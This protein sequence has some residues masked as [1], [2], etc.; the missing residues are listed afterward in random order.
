M[1][2]SLVV[3]SR[4]SPILVHPRPT[5]VSGLLTIVMPLFAPV[6][7][8]SMFRITWR[9][10]RLSE[11]LVA[12]TDLVVVSN[13]NDPNHELLTFGQKVSDFPDAIRCD[14]GDMKQSNG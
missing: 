7:F 14:L 10:R 8:S 2:V 5:I 1:L 11:F 4:P 12:E 6:L 3:R 13:L 9:W